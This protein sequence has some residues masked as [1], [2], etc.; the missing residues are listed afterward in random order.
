[1]RTRLAPPAPPAEGA[2]SIATWPNMAESFTHSPMHSLFHSLTQ[3]L[4]Y[5]ASGWAA[6]TE[7]TSVKARSTAIVSGPRL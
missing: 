6:S 2:R 5:P 4:V 7:L 3:T 1:M